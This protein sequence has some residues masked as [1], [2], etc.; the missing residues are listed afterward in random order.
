MLPE[1]YPELEI[2]CPQI[3]RAEMYNMP[4]CLIELL[5]W[6]D[7]VTGELTQQARELSGGI[8]HAS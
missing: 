5:E 2:I 7:I 6:N 8:L 4:Q 1:K 3:D